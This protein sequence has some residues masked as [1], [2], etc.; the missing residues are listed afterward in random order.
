MLSSIPIL[1]STCYS[2]AMPSIAQR[3]NSQKSVTKVEGGQSG[4][5]LQTGFAEVVKENTKSAWYMTIIITGVGVTAL[6]FYAIFRELFSGKSPNNVYAKAVERCLKDPK[7]LD[8]LGEP[9]KAFGEETRR[10]R[11]GHV[12][13]SLHTQN[14]VNHMR[15]Q[16]YIQ[17]IRKR[18][19]VHLEVRENESG[20]YVYRYLFVQLEDLARNVIVLEDNR[21]SEVQQNNFGSEPILS[22]S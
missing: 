9:V 22:L 1:S 10:G 6:M 8:S 20:D 12:R 16:F 21:G 7:I 15:M 3:Y 18:G 13:H 2:N 5:Q 17:G 14:G 11:R 4:G 19:T